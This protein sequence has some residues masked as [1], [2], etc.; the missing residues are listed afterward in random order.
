MGAVLGIV[1]TAGPGNKSYL[2]AGTRG[3]RRTVWRLLVAV[4]DAAFGEVVGGHL[5]GDAI[6]GE[7]ADA[8][9]AEFASE[10]GENGAF[11]VKLDAEEPTGKFFHNGARDFYRILFTHRAIENYSVLGGLAWIR[12]KE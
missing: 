6:A 5:D 4:G 8:I 12:P 10:V 11:L 1:A 2:F 3:G 7:N 9:A